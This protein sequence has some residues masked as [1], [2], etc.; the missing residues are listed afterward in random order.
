MQAKSVNAAMGW[1]WVKCGWN[2]FARDFGTWFL[3]FLALIVISIAV[4]F[5]P[6]IGPLAMAV[7]MPV[8]LGGY[9]Y[10]SRELD[11]GS[12]ISIGSLFQGFR[13]KARMNKL[14][15][16][17]VIY[18]AI[19]ILLTIA[20]FSMLGGTAMMSMDDSGQID[21]ATITM[22]AGMAIGMLLV[23]LGGIVISMGFFFA[24]ALVMLD[25][26]APVDAIKTSFSACLS[27]ILPMLNLQVIA[28][29]NNE[30]PIYHHPVTARC[31]C[32]RSACR[33][34]AGPA[35]PALQDRQETGLHKISLSVRQG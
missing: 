16:L 27:N 12:N 30:C 29:H 34:G 32:I 26:M 6:F 2:L 33:P 8:F 17:G 13:D 7:I 28:Q 21:P 20:M 23:M 3:M 25:D 11:N 15:V 31:L 18:L 1:S 4:N 35:D 10:A 22:S 24:P 14:L 19:E 5:V 9:M